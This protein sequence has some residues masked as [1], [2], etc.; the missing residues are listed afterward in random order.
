MANKTKYK[1]LSEVRLFGVVKNLS[2]KVK[3]NI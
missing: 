1:A 2:L 3:K